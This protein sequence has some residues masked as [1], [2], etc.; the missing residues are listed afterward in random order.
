MSIGKIRNH[1]VG[2]HEKVKSLQDAVTYTAREQ[3]MNNILK[4]IKCKLGFHTWILQETTVYNPY[5]EKSV[6]GNFWVKA[7][8]VKQHCKNCLKEK[9]V[10]HF[11]I[12]ELNIRGKVKLKES[13][14]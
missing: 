8:K 10:V 7:K 5:I 1:F 9:Q 2:L 6:R 3:K 11:H 4:K 13:K 14:D 12:P